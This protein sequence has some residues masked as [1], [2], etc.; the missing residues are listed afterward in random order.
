MKKISA[1]E[2]I[3]AAKRHIENG[4]SFKSTMKPKDIILLLKRTLNQTL[5]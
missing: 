5:Y 2:R 1:A 4:E 3:N